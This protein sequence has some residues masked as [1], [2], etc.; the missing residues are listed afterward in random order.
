MRAPVAAPVRDGGHRLPLA[1]PRTGGE[2]LVEPVGSRCLADLRDRLGFRRPRRRP[3]PQP[4]PSAH[5]LGRTREQRGLLEVALGECRRRE[6]G[7]AEGH[8][9]G[10]VQRQAQV[11]PFL[12][13]CRRLVQAAPREGQ[14]AQL[15][16]RGRYKPGVAKPLCPPAIFGRARW[17]ARTRAGH[18]RLVDA[19]ARRNWIAVVCAVVAP[20]AVAAILIPVRASF[21]AGA[22]QRPSARPA[23]A[24]HGAG[25]SRRQ[26]AAARRSGPTSAAAPAAGRRPLMR[27]LPGW[28]G[29]T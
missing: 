12:Q 4:G 7:Q 2:R 16:S 5:A 3:G 28:Q 26:A 19:G 15:H 21:H 29:G 22:P 8:V 13:R 24:P 27:C 18:R 6:G 1:E 23:R 9:A 11:E 20:A 25:N 17:S 10:D 14:G